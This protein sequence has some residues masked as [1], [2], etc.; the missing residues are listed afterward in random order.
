MLSEDTWRRLRGQRT[1]WILIRIIGSDEPAL[2]HFVSQF[3]PI[4][5]TP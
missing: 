1:D 3:S 5:S 2:Q 4:I